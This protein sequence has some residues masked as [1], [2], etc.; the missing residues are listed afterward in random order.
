[1]FPGAGFEADFRLESSF[2]FSRFS[3]CGQENPQTSMFSSVSLEQRVPKDHPLRALRALVDGILAN[4]STLFDERYSHTGRHGRCRQGLRHCRID[5]AA[6]AT[7][8][9]VNKQR[10]RCVISFM[11]ETRYA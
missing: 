11:P 5:G 2:Y 10:N 9:N 1:M 4:M 3:M 6:A 7:R 8:H